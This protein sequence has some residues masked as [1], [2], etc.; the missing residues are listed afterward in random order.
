M[1]VRDGEVRQAQRGRPPLLILT[2]T[3]PDLGPYQRSPPPTLLARSNLQD[4]LHARGWPTPISTTQRLCTP[5]RI[6][7]KS[8][9][10][11]LY[12]RAPRDL[13]GGPSTPLPTDASTIELDFPGVLVIRSSYS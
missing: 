8:L 12:G 10:F 5:H 2:K 7:P 3:A 4:R 6:A 11:Q 9:S 1:T 13:S